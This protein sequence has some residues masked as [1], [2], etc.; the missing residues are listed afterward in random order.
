MQVPL[1]CAT[2]FAVFNESAKPVAL[3]LDKKLQS[4]PRVYHHP[5][6]NDATTGMP[7]HCQTIQKAGVCDSLPAMRRTFVFRRLRVLAL[8]VLEAPNYKAQ[9]DI[10]ARI[11]QI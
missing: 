11:S 8:N 1:G 4:K 9:V 5:L 6:T 2:P 3:L 7:A 10:T